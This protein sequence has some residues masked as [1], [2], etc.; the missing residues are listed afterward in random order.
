MSEQMKA[1]TIGEVKTGRKCLF[2]MRT[3]MDISIVVW[4]LFTS[5]VPA[6]IVETVQRP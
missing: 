3:L 4:T 5:Q 6:R 2:R 1:D